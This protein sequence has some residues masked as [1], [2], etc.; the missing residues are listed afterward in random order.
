MTRYIPTRPKSGLR[1]PQ[2]G[3]ELQNVLNS[4]C[5]NHTW[6][7]FRTTEIKNSVK[8][9]RERWSLKSFAKHRCNFLTMTSHL[10]QAFLYII[11][12]I[13]THLMEKEPFQSQ[14]YSSIAELVCIDMYFSMS[15][16]PLFCYIPLKNNSI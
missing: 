5:L 3:R 10:I 14:K 16:I 2:A 7:L 11:L 4:T 12:I 9:W 8:S 6:G 1:C 15:I 13:L